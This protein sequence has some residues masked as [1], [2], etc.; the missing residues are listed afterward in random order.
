MV[1]PSRAQ[2]RALAI[3]KH[4]PGF[5][6]EGEV[7]AGRSGPQTEFGTPA[8]M[9][10]KPAVET[11]SVRDRSDGGHTALS[12]TCSPPP[13]GGSLVSSTVVPGWSSDDEVRAICCGFDSAVPGGAEGGPG[14]GLV[15]APGPTWRF[16]IPPLRT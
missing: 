14:L 16:R 11:V 13:L 6:V 15:V 8:E 5:E 10:S 3:V 1:S 9:K 7:P 4:G 2:V 12:I